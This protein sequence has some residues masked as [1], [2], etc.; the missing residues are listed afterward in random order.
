[1]VSTARLE[2]FADGVFAIAAT[3]LIIDVSVGAD[4][5]ELGSSL[6]HARPQYA[7]YVVSFLTIGIIL[8]NHHASF[9]PIERTDRRF[10]FINVCFLLCVAFIPSPTRLVAEHLHDDGAR[11]ATI[12]YGLTFTATAIFFNLLWF[13]AA[14]G[15]RLIRADA[16]QRVVS[17]ISRSYIPGVPIYALATALAF[18]SPT[19]AVAMFGSIALFYAVERSVF[20]TAQRACEPVS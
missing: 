15:R 8:V 18:V 20:G 14:T 10:L 3:L 19:A 13:Y 6:A 11:A 9:S 1:G 4:G 12:A 7:A 17:G 5:S 2:T 16:D